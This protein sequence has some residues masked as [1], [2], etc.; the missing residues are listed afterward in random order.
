MEVT[1]SPEPLMQRVASGDSA[2]RQAVTR[3]NAEQASK[4]LMWEPTQQ[5][6]GEGRRRGL[7][8]ANRSLPRSHRGNG[9]GMLAHGNRAQHGKPQAA[10][11]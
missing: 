1:I 9:D 5:R 2:S 8:G 7:R 4:Q 11:A 10:G 6:D 3:V